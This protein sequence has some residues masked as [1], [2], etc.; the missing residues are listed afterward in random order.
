PVPPCQVA[1][2]AHPGPPHSSTAAAMR[3]INCPLRFDFIL[4]APCHGLCFALIKKR[5]SATA[6]Q[7]ISAIGTTGPHGHAKYKKYTK[8]ITF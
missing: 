4:V 5:S 2:C 7:H 1:F 3:P 8:I 6:G